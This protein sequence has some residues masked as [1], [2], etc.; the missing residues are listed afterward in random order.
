MRATIGGF[1]GIHLAH[2]ELIKRADLVIIIEK[3]SSLTPGFDRVYYF[4]KA[5]EYLKLEEIKQKSADEFMEYLKSL[6]IKKII[7]GEDFRFGKKREGDIKLLKKE[8]KVEVIR[9]IKKDNIPIHSKI[10][11]ELI[12]KN[13]IKKASSLLGRNYKIKGTKIKG[14]GLG[15]KELLP[16]INIELIKPYTLPKGV[17]ITKTNSYP[18]ITFIGKRS[19]DGNFSIETHILTPFEEKKLIEIEFIEFLRENQKFDTISD[20]KKQILNDI[21]RAKEF[22]GTN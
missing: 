12:K 8:F 7:I 1:D 18:S 15:G 13:K 14:Q 17:F 6:N 10:I 11:R 16:T 2:Q 9:E 3:G 5:F 20:L 21:K 22:Y 19:T 4:D